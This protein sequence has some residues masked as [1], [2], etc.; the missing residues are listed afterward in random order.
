MLLLH[1]RGIQSR[2]QITG[3]S[4]SVCHVRRVVEVID[5]YPCDHCYVCLIISLINFVPF[6]LL[7][8]HFIKVS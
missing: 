4:L 1:N 7:R 8:N 5:S 3:F 2:V 6:G